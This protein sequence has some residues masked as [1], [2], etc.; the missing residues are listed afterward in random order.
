M[1]RKLLVTSV[2][3]GLATLVSM[4]AF[5]QSADDAAQEEAK[6]KE[7]R[8]ETVMVTGSL[9][10]QAE[11]ETASPVITISAQQI[12]RQGFG[13]VYE[14]LRA[15][16]LATGSVQDNQ[17][18]GGFTPGAETLSLLGL[19]PG[20]TLFLING[21]PLSDYPLLYN[22]VSNFVDLS[23]IPTGMV[24]HIDILPGNQSSIYGSSAIAGV[25][26]V[27]LKDKIDGY[28]LNI[29]GG[30]FT[31]GGGANERIEFLGGQ[32]WGD[33]QAT[34]G[35]QLNNQQPIWSF[36]RKITAST[37]SSP[38]P[39]TRYGTRNFLWLYYD[40][41]FAPH[42][43]DPGQDACAPVA[44][45][46]GGTTGYDFRPGEGF[47]CGSRYN[48]GY[49]TIRDQNRGGT[50]YLNIKY[51][52]SET[53]ELYGDLLYSVSSIH[54]SPGPY[55]WESNINGQ[56]LFIDAD[57]GRFESVQHIFSP[58]EIGNSDL[59]S[60]HNIVRSYSTW[61]GLQGTVGT[62]WDYNFYYARSQTNLNDKTP[63]L[64]TDK[65]NNFFNSQILG[66]QLGTYYGYPVYHSPN[67][68]NLYKPVTPA[69]Y[70]GLIG[71]IETRS[72]TWTQNL[73]F[74]V[75]NTDLFQLPAG[76]VG[77]AGIVQV[78]N[79]AWNNPTDPALLAGDF[80]GL[81]GTPGSG[82]RNNY[83]SAIE[84]RAPIFSTLTA[85]ASVRY[86]NY[87]NQNVSGGDSKATYKLGLEYRPVESLLIRGN[88]ATAFRA[89]DMAYT[90]GGQ[91][92]FFQQGQTDYYRCAVQQPNVPLPQCTY[93]NSTQIFGIHTGNPAL[94]SVTAKSFGFGGVWSPTAN[95][96]VKADY[97]NVRITNEVSL[98]SVDQ[99]LRDES[100]CLLGN[101]DITS[102]T[103]QAAISQ[104]QRA[105]VS[106][107]PNSQAIESVTVLPINISNER[108]SGV[109]T[110]LHYRHDFGA[111]GNLA[112]E[113]NYNVTLKH[114]AQTYPQ[115]P[116]IDL[117]REPF[118]SAE[119]KSIATASV[120]W[121][122]DK[123]SATLLETR[124]GRTPN[125]IA[126]TNV[127][128]Y[129]TPG[130]GT[131]APWILYNGSLTYSFTDDLRVSG[132]VNNVFNKM[133]PVDNTWVAYPFYNFLNFNPYGRSY[134]LEM[135]WRFGHSSS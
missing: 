17:T 103:C 89:P 122:I 61:G 88:Y 65:V 102:P 1:K 38:S 31:G 118:Y 34:F 117:L 54:S 116:V 129:A 3:T 99:L 2:A 40:S 67:L 18:N 86:D 24:D 134:W 123:F 121:T 16:P 32:S 44:K 37:N 14:A 81:T 48:V 104:V 106:N 98:Q 82:T 77:V 6:K 112:L 73:N 108:V 92:G 62:P 133:P 97:Y 96:D 12:E 51:K 69:E 128:G 131:V 66:P 84:L 132:I 79:Q 71:V 130:A 20:F 7:A 52:L 126:Q 80:Y 63:W 8:L 15:Q 30:G 55:F 127:T 114:S 83:A 49:S 28:E 35:I 11:V 75:S 19:D 9:I 107:S 43:I 74:Q 33:L 29:R 25:V 50:G 105:P 135:D 124:Y 85:D 60:D 21:H 125:Y 109:Y 68:T 78:G 120:T 70:A 101:L 10:P 36:D 13:T 87:S 59:Y 90:F 119:F 110:S 64:L 115:D 72:E 93:Y 94:Q 91:S 27:I 41:N 45:L 23:N 95:F 113:G 47:F 46:N 4:H 53:T 26:N 5:A 39:L 22:G 57:T 100:A 56:G 58:E 111:W 76:P 42:Y